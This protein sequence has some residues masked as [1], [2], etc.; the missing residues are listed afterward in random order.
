MKRWVSKLLV[1]LLSLFSLAA[2]LTP[3]PPLVW[4]D[5]QA[6]GSHLVPINPHSV[7]VIVRRNN[8]GLRSDPMNHGYAYR[9]SSPIPLPPDWRRAV[10]TGR[11]WRE[12]S[13]QGDYPEMVLTLF[14][15]YPV[16]VHGKSYDGR[17]LGNYLE[18]AYDSWNR[19]IRFSDQGVA[20]TAK[21][22]RFSRKMPRRPTPFRLTLRREAGTGLVLWSFAEKRE[23]RWQ[24]IIEGVPTCL[25]EGTDTRWLYWKIGGWSSGTR[26]VDTPLHFDRLTYRIENSV[27]RT[28]TPETSGG[29][30][31]TQARVDDEAVRT[32]LEH[33]PRLP[34]MHPVHHA[35]NDVKTQRL[36]LK[37]ALR[38]GAMELYY[39]EFTPEE[40]ADFYRHALPESWHR[41]VSL[42]SPGEGGIL[43]WR[44][45]DLSLQIYVW[46]AST[47]GYTYIL[48]GCGRRI[49]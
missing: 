43:T 13:S 46:P 10:F 4:H 38:P 40:V 25:F 5:C 7:D 3:L 19:L 24:Q 20:G 21:L 16:L 15:R 9:L 8:G 48:L 36:R 12:A 42:F 28:S 39:A 44:R 47:R 32:C 18:V 26:P 45:G 27:Q 49:K 30:E 22:R 34:L 35:G 14:S 31:A 41:E 37:K 29:G 6:N 23:G 33:L 2:A 1:P 11:W 17:R